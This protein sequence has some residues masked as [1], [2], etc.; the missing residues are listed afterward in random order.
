VEPQQ[1]L[2]NSGGKRAFRD[3]QKPGIV[4]VPTSV[5]TTDFYI[6]RNN[7]HLQNQC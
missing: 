7:Y 6:N 2:R 1:K 3:R 4:K 5:S